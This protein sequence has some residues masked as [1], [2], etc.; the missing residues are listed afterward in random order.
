MASRII[1]L[2]ITDCISKSYEYKDKKRLELG[3]ILPDAIT[4]GNSHLKISLSN[5]T[6]KTYDLTSN[7]LS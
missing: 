7:I 3:S 4:S 2:A 1:H 6:K 5:G